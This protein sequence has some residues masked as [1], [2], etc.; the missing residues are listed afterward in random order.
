VTRTYD[1][2]PSPEAA[3][4]EAAFED[5]VELLRQAE[6]AS[7]AAV[8]L[9]I[10]CSPAARVEPEL[11]RELRLTVA[12]EFDA[13]AEAELWFG[14]LVQ[15]RSAVAIAFV[16]VV[17]PLLRAR[18]L[19]DPAATD[20]R[21][22]IARVHEGAPEFIRLEEE[23]TWLTLA[24]DPHAE[25][26]R[27]RL[28]RVL[29]AAARSPTHGVVRW[30]G[31]MLGRL[32]A[33]ARA[34]D[35]AAALELL[36]AGQL[37]EPL[38]I[39]LAPSPARAQQAARL[40]SELTPLTTETTPVY[41]QLFPSRLVLSTSEEQG[42]HRIEAAATDPIVVQVSWSQRRRH[43]ETRVILLPRG[44]T[45]EIAC[46]DPRTVT[47]RAAGVPRAYVLSA[48]TPEE[49]AAARRERAWATPLRDRLQRDIAS[50]AIEGFVGREALL[51]RIATWLSPNQREPH[52]MVLTGAA[53][54][55]KTAVAAE[56]ARRH[57]LTAAHFA[58]PRQPLT[59]QWG[60]LL[61]TL[62]RGLLLAPVTGPAYA[63]ALFDADAPPPTRMAREAMFELVEQ[64]LGEL[65]GPDAMTELLTAPLSRMHF[66]APV[67]ILVDGISDVA[68][69]D[70]LVTA[71]AHLDQ[72]LKLLATA[73][74]ARKR[75]GSAVEHIAVESFTT[76]EHRQLSRQAGGVSNA[77]ESWIANVIGIVPRQSRFLIDLFR[78]EDR[79]WE[80][81][82]KD[83]GNTARPSGEVRSGLFA[84]VVAEM[85]RVTKRS[86]ADARLVLCVLDAAREPMGL[87]EFAQ[88]LGGQKAVHVRDVAHCLELLYPLVKPVGR[89]PRYVLG[90]DLAILPSLVE[91]A[92]RP[93][94]E[95]HRILA[96]L[97]EQ[98]LRRLDSDN[99]YMLRHGVAHLLQVGQDH[100]AAQLVTDPK[101]IQAK[102][103]AD[104]IGG[105]TDDL[106][107][108]ALAIEGGRRE[109]AVA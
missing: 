81:G 94:D 19:G 48:A 13:S 59:Q 22:A 30:A 66:D 4:A 101:W 46:E 89:E 71:I 83:V 93:S 80:G 2:T 103:R 69:F 56:I 6:V 15:S 84:A 64:R 5:P 54:I 88:H 92:S 106:D 63:A 107:A 51:E 18:L 77:D 68:M 102:L 14:P 76:E 11:I 67:S 53:G 17:L 9:A 52:A 85:D 73:A 75:D 98:Q 28:M 86:S 8:R 44:E 37:E 16:P 96:N 33:Q 74:Y 72:P 91:S 27:E 39:V 7:P 29:A 41:V 32:P 79:R 105:L 78:H 97:A 109:P 24:G 99:Q 100:V 1:A 61:R 49:R 47:I 108:V 3:R 60:A 36:V 82:I 38:P 95:G 23:V 90:H 34:V 45:R 70:L 31:R 87:T 104:G 58:T 25:A 42:G 40:L 21:A 12:P 55:G 35:A 26:V 62:V 50:A 20:A 57:R 43:T 65:S 10:L